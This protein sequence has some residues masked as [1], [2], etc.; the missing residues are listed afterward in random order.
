MRLRMPNVGLPMV[1]KELAEMAQRRRTYAARVV[2]AALV[3][4]ISAVVFVPTY[5]FATRSTIGL[6]GQGARLLNTLYTVEWFMLCLFVPAIVS[7]VIAAEKERNTLQ[8]L[9]LTR[10]GPWTIL[11]EKLLS[12]F[13]PIG[14]FVLVSL[15]LLFVAYLFGGLT[16]ND[17][18]FAALGL[19]STVFQLGCISLFCSAF[20]ATAASALIASYF[21]TILVFLA[22][23]IS[24]VGARLLSYL[25]L[26]PLGYTG[27]ERTYGSAVDSASWLNATVGYSFMGSL[28]SG[29]PWHTSRLPLIVIPCSGFLF[30]G[31]ARLAIVRRA[32]P[33]PKQ[34]IRRLFQALDRTFKRVNDRYARGVLVIR[35]GADLPE[36]DPVAWR[37]KRRGNL[38]RLNYLVRILLFTEGPILALLVFAAVLSSASNFAPLHTI[39]FLL[40]PIAILVVIVRAA[41]VVA[42]EKA[43]QTLDILVATPLPLSALV[44]S[45]MKSVRRMMLIVALPIALQSILVTYLQG[46]AGGGLLYDSRH[47][48]PIHPVAYVATTLVNLVI[49]LG[50]AAELAFLFG[51]RAKTQGRAVTAVLGVFVGWCILPLLV[52]VFVDTDYV[53]LYFSPIGSVLVNEFPELGIDR[54]F[55]YGA[56]STLA[57]AFKKTAHAEI[58]AVLLL[59][60]VAINRLEAGRALLR[61]RRLARSRLP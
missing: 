26:V 13:V 18:T 15:P 60:L 14:S 35:S 27:F 54:T 25:V 34:R 29:H 23:P 6:L 11:L 1:A 52:R 7:G 37:E 36:D 22:G 12:R 8:L 51:L 10:L 16:Q 49:V 38:G 56:Q 17:M 4:S 32:T 2:F 43:R 30:L 40:W 9:F 46:I 39:G 59:V 45:K 20:Y 41:G 3:F 58:Y 19:V 57:Q 48:H 31:L 44:G 61:P 47:R 53:A 33:Q 21:L 55:G 5:L 50:L 24:F 28:L 42:A